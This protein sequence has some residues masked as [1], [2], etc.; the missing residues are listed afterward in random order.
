MLE[1]KDPRKPSFKE[2]N[3]LQKTLISIKLG[4]NS[5]FRIVPSALKLGCMVGQRRYDI[6][7]A[8]KKVDDK[9]RKFSK[10]RRAA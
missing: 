10:G 3:V 9:R 8:Q 5:L 1:L 7:K 6:S 4:L 2:W